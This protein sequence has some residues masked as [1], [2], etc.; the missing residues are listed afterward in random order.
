MRCE[1]Q[2][3]LDSLDFVAADMDEAH[4]VRGD[5]SGDAGKKLVLE[6]RL[7]ILVGHAA[8][9]KESMGVDQHASELAASL[10][11]SRKPVEPCCSAVSSCGG[12]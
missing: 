6:L 3:V 11:S 12:L 8:Y 5:Q 10:H 4:L 1:A 7:K 9:H 2:G